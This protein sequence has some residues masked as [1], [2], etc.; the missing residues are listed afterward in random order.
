MQSSK[1]KSGN[2][3][4]VDEI[5]GKANDAAAYTF[6]F[7]RNEVTASSYWYWPMRTKTS[8]PKGRVRFSANR[9]GRFSIYESSSWTCTAST[10][11]GYNRDRSSS[12]TPTC[13]FCAP[14]TSTGY[15]I[16]TTGTAIFTANINVAED[17]DLGKFLFKTSTDYLFEFLNSAGDTATA[18]LW[19]DFYE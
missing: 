4:A 9:G 13:Y 1:D 19:I 14:T 5:T 8:P 6:S 10:A 18:S 17:Y 15:G 3:V 16:T 12:N 2:L 11:T 7:Y